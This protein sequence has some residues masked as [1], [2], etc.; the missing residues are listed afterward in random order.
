M[1]KALNFK[2]LACLLLVLG[3]GASCV[4]LLHAVQAGRNA[5]ALLQQADRAEA[6]GQLDRA[7]EYLE[8][9]LA[10]EPADTDA[11][12]RYGFLLNKVADAEEHKSGRHYRNVLFTF[13][14]VLARAPG[15]HDVRRAF[16]DVAM[17]FR[18]FAEARES[19]EFLLRDDPNDGKLRLL[20]AECYENTEGQ[21]FDK[22]EAEYKKALQALPH[23]VNGYVLYARLLRRWK[24]DSQQADAV[25]DGMVRANPKDF[26]AYLARSDYRKKY[27]TEEQ[28]N[29]DIRQAYAL[30]PD[31]SQVLRA[32][33]RLAL[34]QRHPDFEKARGYLGHALELHPDDGANYRALARL[35]GQ[36][37][38]RPE[39]I[40]CLRRA[41]EAVPRGQR[42]DMLWDLANVLAEKE[43]GADEAG[44]LLKGAGF[45]ATHLHLLDAR[46]LVARGEW[47][48]ASRK[49]ESLSKDLL[50]LPE[51]ATQADLLLGYCYQQ[52]GN[53]DQQYVVY[54]RAEKR[55]A[56][57]DASLG[58]AS[59]LVGMGR[60]DEA[61]SAYRRLVLRKPAL[62]L[63]V[64]RL[65]VLRNQSLPRAER[66][67]REAEALLRDAAKA[68]PDDVAEVAVLQAEVKAWQSETKAA[69][70]LLLKAREKQQK[71]PSLW[72]AS[73]AVEELEG[74]SEAA[75]AILEE[76][77]RTL[78]DPVEVR[79]A[80]AR[81][82]GRH[83]GPRARPALAKLSQDVRKYKPEDQDRLLR[84][85]AGAYAQVEDLAEARR[86][87]AELA[88]RRPTD[89]GIRAVLFALALDANDDGAI[90]RA[91]ADIRRIEGEE[92]GTLWRYG[93]ACHLIWQARK[94]KQEGQDVTATLDRAS[95]FVDEAAQRR[96]AWSA[97]PAC[98]AQIDVL[99]G[100]KAAAVRDYQRAVNELGNR[101]P[102]T[103]RQFVLLLHEFH[104][105]AEAELVLR[106]L[107]EELS[108][109]PAMERV[110][111][112]ISVGVQDYERA[113]SLAEKAI[114]AQ[115]KDYRDYLWLGIILSQSPTR[116]AE[117]ERA[118]RQAVALAGDKPEARVRLV[119][120][121]VNKGAK[122]KAVAEVRAAEGKIPAAQAPLALAPCYEAIG[123]LAK[124]DKL[125]E[126]AL[127]AQPDDVGTLRT[128]AAAELR[129]GRWDGAEA[130][131]RKII[132]LAITSK[133]DRAWARRVLALVLTARGDYQHSR[134]AL[135][136]LGIL[137]EDKQP[138]AAAAGSPA[139]QRTLAVVLAA[140]RTRRQRRDAIRILENLLAQEPPTAEDQFLL[141]QL[142]ES[143]GDWPQ[144][145]Q[146]MVNL[147]SA[148][149]NNVLYLA[150]FT[151]VLLDHQ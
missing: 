91:V 104:R 102:E 68:M 114:S 53:P 76:A 83:P 115:S 132:D 100:N 29:E 117:A 62:R 13:S 85:L 9:Y 124:A 36:A 28:A 35:E 145:R 54:R 92:D 3:L 18:Q 149:S 148:D 82:W 10:H 105:Y 47:L 130:H 108:L 30:A 48:N 45:P 49:L 126:K 57:L 8:R 147:L 23:D 33:A 123:D 97:L 12:A 128:V 80:L 37:Q 88:R 17:K 136:T 59:A 129:H 146:Q 77:A 98:A 44:K 144:A 137:G 16:V 106:K 109:S 96:P 73:A 43:E 111:A 70:A 42:R 24:S 133:D 78:K 26:R 95:G 56:S 122:E 134:E 138:G 103:I 107:P 4:H 150:Y 93:E 101:N 64:A 99:K 113:V 32:M 20:L 34:G 75:L 89:L 50:L 72:V 7:S 65:L 25:M 5:R 131:L 39:A 121:L 112:D 40:A 21:D 11:L 120:Y 58:V 41:V 38:R 2:R 14:R 139:D 118:L 84:G 143:V 125:Y 67:W 94:G 52:L 15:R 116:Q 61:I 19:L 119:Q 63:E 127:A 81:Y 141:A 79:L 140:Q 135:N 6:A 86:L 51:L 46:I 90:S 87:W 151:Q 69:R 60:L 55:S 27:A 1:R 71:D 142:Y 31:E 66:D 110:A 74:K 22:A